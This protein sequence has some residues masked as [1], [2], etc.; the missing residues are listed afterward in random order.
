[1]LEKASTQKERKEILELRKKHY[2][3]IDAER[4]EMMDRQFRAIDNPEQYLFVEMDSMDQDKTSVPRMP[5]EPKQMEDTGKVKFHVTAA[6]V[7]SLNRVFEYVYTNN[8]AH[9]GNTTVTILDQVL[10]AVKQTQ[11]FL[12]PVLYLQLDN[13]C[14]ENKNKIMFSYLS[15]LVKAKVFKKIYLGFLPVGHTHFGCDQVFSRHSIALRRQRTLTGPELLKVLFY[16]YTPYPDMKVIGEAADVKSWLADCMS[17]DF[18]GVTEGHQFLFEKIGTE[19]Y[20]RDKLWGISKEYQQGAVL[21]QKLPDQGPPRAP[22]RHLFFSHPKTVTA[23]GLTAD[24]KAKRVVAELEASVNKAQSCFEALV[25][26]VQFLH[27]NGYIDEQEKFWWD[28]FIATQ[29]DTKWNE[30]GKIM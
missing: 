20:V 26:N 18:Q 11:G 19:V 9:D 27:E 30:E 15:L 23:K 1:M 7:P 29:Q 28:T 4:Q 16:S 2:R 21:L 10:Q 24:E 13:T 17:K 6:K 5:R 25:K 12:P 14:R 8:L 3:L 22:R